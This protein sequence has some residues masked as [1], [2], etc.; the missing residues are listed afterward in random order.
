M[1]CLV[2][3]SSNQTEFVAEVHIHFPEFE[4]SGKPGVLIFPK[5]LVCLDCGFAS[6]MTPG[7]ELAQ[8][9]ATDEPHA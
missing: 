5:L 6:F 8:L 3:A 9:C 4:N 1:P 2:C 7:S